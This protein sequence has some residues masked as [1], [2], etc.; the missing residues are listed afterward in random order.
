AGM[1]NGLLITVVGITPILATLGTM[2]LYNGIAIVVTR[3]EAVYGM[4]ESFLQIGYGDVVGIPISFWLFVVA[5]LVLAVVINRTALGARIKLVGAN[6]T[7]A[8]FSGIGNRRVLILTYVTAGV[9]SGMAG[10]LM[11]A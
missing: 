7:A 9:L 6:P 8:R 5:A 3:G 4:P 11:A 1:F 2:T 10:V